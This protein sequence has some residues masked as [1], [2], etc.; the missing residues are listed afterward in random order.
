MSGSG[1]ANPACS[2]SFQ[3]SSLARYS[4]ALDG[5]SQILGPKPGLVRVQQRVGSEGRAH[6][7]RSESRDE[8]GPHLPR[9]AVAPAPVGRTR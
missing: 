1:Y 2:P 3:Y 9:E 5:W 6:Q 7:I 8:P 4:A